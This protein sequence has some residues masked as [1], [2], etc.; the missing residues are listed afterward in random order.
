VIAL[1]VGG[2]KK[3][4]LRKIILVAIL[5]NMCLTKIAMRWIFLS[6]INEK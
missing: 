2:F 5:K 4:G 6:K 1:I 3:V